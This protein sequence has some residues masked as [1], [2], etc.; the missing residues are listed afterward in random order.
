MKIAMIGT[1]YVGLV[2]GTCFAEFGHD[3]VCVDKDESKIETLKSGEIPIYEPGL[4]ELVKRNCG[5]GR[6]SFTTDL[7]STVKEAEVCIIAVG[8]PMDHSGAADLSAVMAVAASIAKEPPL[9]RP[10]SK[11]PPNNPSMA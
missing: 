11:T 6:L 8:T 5:E 4:E 1:G 10:H 9:P 3:V 2:S 7:D